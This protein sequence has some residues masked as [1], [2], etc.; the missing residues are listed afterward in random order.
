MAFGSQTIRKLALSGA[1]FDMPAD[2]LEIC[3]A[4]VISGKA[5]DV[6]QGV[7]QDVALP[8]SLPMPGLVL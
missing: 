4:G 1:M 6:P 5:Q 3:R 2:A 8:L 7:P